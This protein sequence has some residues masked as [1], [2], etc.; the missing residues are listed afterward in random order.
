MPTIQDYLNLSNAAYTTGGA[1]ASAPPGFTLMTDSSGNPLMESDPSG[2]QAFAFQDQTTGQII[3]AY[4]GTNL[5]NL[6]TNQSYL[7]DQIAADAAIA[8]GTTP[9][10]NLNAL[11]FIVQKVAPYAGSNPI[12]LTGHSLGGEEAEYVE[13]NASANNL[14]IAGGAVFAAPGVPNQTPIN[15]YNANFTTYLD[16][17]DA[18]GNFVPTDGSHVGD[19]QYV[20]NALAPTIEDNLPLLGPGGGAEAVGMA[21]SDHV[22][23]NYAND[24]GV[25][26]ASTSQSPSDSGAADITEMSSLY[27]VPLF[28]GTGSSSPQDVNGSLSVNGELLTAN[29]GSVSLGLPDGQ[30][31]LVLDG[32]GQT[33]S[34]S[35]NTQVVID[36]SSDTVTTGSGAYLFANGT[37]DTLTASNDT[38]GFGTNA[39]ATIDGSSNTLTCSAGDTLTASGN[40]IDLGNDLTL[41]ASGNSDTFNLG[42]GSTL[43]DTGAGSVIDASGSTVDLSGSSSATLNGNDNTWNGMAFDTFTANGNDNTLNVGVINTVTDTGTG[44]TLDSLWGVDNINFGNDVSA[45]VT[46][47]GGNT[48]TCSAGDTLTASGNTIDLGNDLTL[49]ASGNSDT[50]DGGTDDT[51]TCSGNSN[52]LNLGSGSLLTVTGTD[53]GDQLN[54]SSGTVDFNASDSSTMDVTGSNDISYS[55]NALSLSALNFSGT[56][57]VAYWDNTSNNSN[58]SEYFDPNSTV[59]LECDYYSGGLN[60]QGTGTD[61]YLNFVGG[62]SQHYMFSGLPSDVTEQVDQFTGAFNGSADTGTETAVGTDFTAGNSQIDLLDSG[63][64]GVSSIYENYSGLNGTGTHQDDYL[65]FSGGGSQEDI[66]TGLSSGVTEQADVFAGGTYNGTTD[67]GTLSEIGTD[68]S[69]NTSQLQFLDPGIS[70]VSTVYENFSGLNGTGNNLGDYLDYQGGGTEEV[71][72][73]GLPSGVADQVDM[74]TGTYDGS[75]ATSLGNEM[76]IG[77]DLSSAT[78]GGDLSQLELLDYSNNLPTDVTTEYENFSGLYGGGS[79]TSDFLDLS[80]GTSQEFFDTGLPTGTTQQVQ[81]YDGTYGGLYGDNSSLVMTGTGDNYS[82]GTCSALLYNP[83][84]GVSSEAVDWSGSLETLGSEQNAS[85]DFSAG[86]SQYQQFTGLSTGISMEYG[87]YSGANETG[88]LDNLTADF[89]NG[90]SQTSIYGYSSASGISSETDLWSGLNDGGYRLASDLATTT[91]ASIDTTYNYSGSTLTSYDESFYSSSNTLLGSADFNSSGTFISGDTSLSGAGNFGTYGNVSYDSS[92]YNGDQNLGGYTPLS[93]SFD[94]TPTLSSGYGYI[95]SSYFG[96][97]SGGYYG[98]F[99]GGYSF[100][101]YGFAGSAS[102]AVNSKNIGI[103]AQYDQQHWDG[104]AATAAENALQQAHGIATSTPSAGTGSA[105]LEGGKWDQRVI[106]WSLADSA[107]TGASPFSSDMNSTD[108]SAVQD[109]IN[110]WA[111]VMP[112]VTFEQVADSSQSDIRIGFGDFNTATTGIVGYTSGRINQGQ[113]EPD[114]I[115]RVEDPTQDPL[116]L[117]SNGQQVYTGTDAT[118]TQA[119][120][121]EL[122]HALGFGLNTDSNSIMYYLLDSSNRSLDSTDIAGAASLYGSTTTAA[123]GSTTGNSSANQLVQAMASVNT[124]SGAT[125]LF[126]VPSTML[127]HNITLASVPM[128]RMHA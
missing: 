82:N 97:N 28:G 13:A 37:G 81:L 125:D 11:N 104:A 61:A 14:N 36:G 112:G 18:L 58:V 25:T 15:S 50:L 117:G 10:A 120:E 70:G 92:V 93:S 21:L 45:T 86:G 54:L 123:T 105:V 43:N 52:T 84:S 90:E 63:V 119:I 87:D 111:A 115:V 6:G 124:A 32:N 27:G 77:T 19:V 99:G 103:I 49:A 110:A 94:Y 65:N 85:F 102:E 55:D 51:L 38:I 60:G 64:S 122:G 91:G 29:S 128:L 100:G 1:A 2:M 24:F 48:L 118:L 72:S 46:G 88:Q 59:A 126:S 67:T 53:T 30:T 96:G 114:M 62:G 3:V 108:A 57:D 71:L 23:S 109:A 8:N 98:S 47:H 56:G 20:G 16:Y 76:A 89:T 9:Q 33:T 79:N 42:T 101:G 22:L 74:Y 107:G 39:S 17:G 116:V 68:F 78:S 31:S 35:P 80:N 95:P 113:F 121:H 4:E 34:V 106:T 66:L 83:E 73:T 127:P 5:S 44:N 69:T 12:Y 75:T 41:A 26:L 40:T 7:D